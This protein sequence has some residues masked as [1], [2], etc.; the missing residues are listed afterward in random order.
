MRQLAGF[1]LVQVVSEFRAMRASVLALWRRVEPA[2]DAVSAIDEIA[3]FNE[4]MDQALAESIQRY[5]SDVAV[6]LAVV[7]HE[8]RT[9]L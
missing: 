9:P 8:L 1:D 6:F 3:R 4:A 2:G 7:G 5:S